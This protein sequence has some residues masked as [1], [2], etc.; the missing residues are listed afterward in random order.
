MQVLIKELATRRVEHSR[1]YSC[2]SPDIWRRDGNRPSPAAFFVRFT[3]ATV[4][5]HAA[6][7]HADRGWHFQV[8]SSSGRKIRCLSD[9]VVPRGEPGSRGGKEE[10]GRGT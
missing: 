2:N 4:I 9:H 10:T 1:R 3:S 5:P 7:S 6:S 8:T